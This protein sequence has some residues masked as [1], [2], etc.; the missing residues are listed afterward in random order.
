V[1]NITFET[2]SP[3]SPTSC[4]HVQAGGTSA[5]IFCVA[6]C[7]LSRQGPFLFLSSG[8]LHQEHCQRYGQPWWLPLAVAAGCSPR[9]KVWY[10]LHSSQCASHWVYR[11]AQRTVFL[12]IGQIRG[13][14]GAA[15]HGATTGRHRRDHTLCH[16]WLTVT[17]HIA[18]LPPPTPTPHTHDVRTGLF[19]L[20]CV[21]HAQTAVGPWP[22]LGGN[23]QRSALSTYPGP[24]VASGPGAG[25]HAQVVSTWE[26]LT[27]GSVYSSPAVDAWGNVFIGSS[28]KYLYALEG[29]SGL[30]LWCFKTGADV[31]STPAVSASGVVFFGSTDRFVYAV[32]ATSGASVW[33]APVST[34]AAVMSSPLLCDDGRLYV[35][36]DVF[37][38][39]IAQD[40]GD[41]VWSTP[42]SLF[43][44]GT[45]L[46]LGSNQ[47]LIVAGLKRVLGLDCRNGSV[48]WTYGH[49]NEHDEDFT[50]AAVSN[51]VAY[52][53]CAMGVVSAVN[54]LDG[55]EV[56]TFNATRGVGFVSSPAIGPNGLVYI[57]SL[58]GGLYALAQ[59]GTLAW[60]Y[61]AG[62]R[63]FT[64]PAVDANGV[65]Y[66]GCDD[67]Q[68]HAVNGS[69]GMLLWT[70]D[71]GSDVR[72]SPALTSWGTIIV[73]NSAGFVV[74]VGGAFLPA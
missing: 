39:A 37:V 29:R 3:T 12:K 15:C 59:N 65:V 51:G 47:T 68:L 61:A 10:V 53:G 40:T 23:P 38:L 6:T 8:E 25:G 2:V 62:E 27:G 64:T 71:I 56:W 73:G 1:L 50:T 34:P 45:S 67:N 35:L 20:A 16:C 52:L 42:F 58:D 69:T 63:A 30:L 70:Y 31:S 54:V 14:T 33:D 28:D 5:H 48:I 72:S 24:P 66:F 26:F 7:C 46:A 11:T 60:R 43:A 9:R 49:P 22:Q 32:N 21:A 19:S 55:S 13:G 41:V 4:L 57:A 36:S 17:S 74:S 18:P 44:P